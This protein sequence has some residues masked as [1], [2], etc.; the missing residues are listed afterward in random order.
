MKKE[1]EDIV[2]ELLR[3]CKKYKKNYV[4][5][6][7]INESIMADISVKDKDYDKIRVYIAEKDIRKK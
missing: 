7:Y 4:T 2:I 5:A 6:C 3:W 1:L